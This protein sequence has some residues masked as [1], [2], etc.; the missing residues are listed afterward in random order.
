ME[1]EESGRGE[2]S[3]GRKLKKNKQ[4]IPAPP[5]LPELRRL[6]GLLAAAGPA[7]RPASPSTSSSSMA[8]L[9]A[10]PG[11]DA[12]TRAGGGHGA[13]AVTRSPGDT[14]DTAHPERCRGHPWDALR[15]CKQRAG[16]PS[17]CTPRA[18]PPSLSTPWC[19]SALLPPQ[20]SP[21]CWSIPCASPASALFLLCPQ[22]EPRSRPSPQSPAA[23][24]A[25]PPPCTAPSHHRNPIPPRRAALTC[26]HGARRGAAGPMGEAVPL[27]AAAFAIHHWFHNPDPEEIAGIMKFF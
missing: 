20:Q 2:G 22:A 5:A 1:G 14:E 11:A 25:Y 4:Q 3:E 6:A 17:P 12:D 7:S 8:G 13:T 15:L 24:W 27:H 18:L 26:R 10:K 16:T 19:F 21:Q 9:P 23:P